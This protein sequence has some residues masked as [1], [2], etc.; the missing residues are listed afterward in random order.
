[1]PE[2]EK[3]VIS[4]HMHEH[5]PSV[6]HLRSTH[7]HRPPVLLGEMC[8]LEL[9]PCTGSPL[10]SRKLGQFRSP[11]GSAREA[12]SRVRD[13]LR[14]CGPSKRNPAT[15][16]GNCRLLLQWDER[17]TFLRKIAENRTG[18]QLQDFQATFSGTDAFAPLKKNSSLQWSGARS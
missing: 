15:G 17:Q 2:P 13:A 3:Q 14:A 12:P 18:I 1:M 4:K 7:N 8:G 10:V 16:G 5:S 9:P 6:T 11:R